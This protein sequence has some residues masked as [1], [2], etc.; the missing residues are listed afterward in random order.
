MSPYLNQGPSSSRVNALSIE[1][2]YTLKMLEFTQT[3][4]LYIWG[5]LVAAGNIWSYLT[6]MDFNQGFPSSR[7]NALFIEQQ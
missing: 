4:Q 3:N 2:E 7:V 5:L 1:L 6:Y